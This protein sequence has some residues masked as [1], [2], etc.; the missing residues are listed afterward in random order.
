MSHSLNMQLA[1][2]FVELCDSQGGMPAICAAPSGIDC[3]LARLPNPLD[4]GARLIGLSSSM[5]RDLAWSESGL[6]FSARV[7]GQA[8]RL[9]LR[10]AQVLFAVDL[11]G[12]AVLRFPDS[13]QCAQELPVQ[14]P[15]KAKP[16]L[17]LVVSR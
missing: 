8:L 14:E 2:A 11:R 4:D 15:A 10:A 12:G 6:S 1:R 13:G 7:Q 16:A 3:P 5:V 9:E 17:R